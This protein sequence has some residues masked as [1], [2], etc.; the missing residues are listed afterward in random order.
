VQAGDLIWYPGHIMMSL[1]VPDLI[2]HARSG[3]RAVE[4]HRI[5]PTRLKWMR[6]VSPLG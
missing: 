6:F 1:G 3:E 4:I 2:V 5:D